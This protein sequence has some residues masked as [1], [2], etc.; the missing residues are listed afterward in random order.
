MRIQ[1][2]L[3]GAS[4][5]LCSAISAAAQTP[6]TYPSTPRASQVDDYHGSKIADPYRW[7]EDSD[8]P[9][10]KAWI[11]AQ[12]RVSFGYLSALPERAP[13][14]N[15]LTQV[16]NYPKY[17]TPRKVDDRLF[18]SENSGLQNQSIF[19]V[20]DG[21]RP[22]RV[23]IDPNTLSTDGTASLATTA[24]SPNGKL[25]AYSISFAGSDWREVRVRN[26]DNGRD[27]ADTLKWVKFSGIS[28]TPRQQGI[29][30][31]G[32]RATDVGQQAHERQP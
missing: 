17:D 28:W 30:L 16:W 14:R 8:S 23:L 15:R 31:P 10:T 18:F 1:R 20:K 2:A 7:L 5:L 24:P 22:Q 4:L 25:L 3:F 19:Y 26:V 27:A 11:E 13:I 21:D 6:V 29:L 9:E 12:N 32:I